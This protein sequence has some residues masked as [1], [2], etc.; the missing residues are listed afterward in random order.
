MSDPTIAVVTRP[1]V[2]Y[3]HIPHPHIQ[4]RRK[5]GPVL[6]KHVLSGLNGRIATRITAVVGTMGCA[7]LF[8]F[9]TLPALPAAIH[10]ST[11]SD[12]IPL[13]SWITQTFIQ[14]VLLPVIMVGQAIQSAAGDARS[15][16]IFNDSEAMLHE[17]VEIQKHMSSQDLLIAELHAMIMNKATEA[18]PEAS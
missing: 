18:S 1:R 7:Y 5:Q 13:I 12:P 17:M 15:L 2:P 6:T 16:Q 11:I 8:V 4:A 14:L 10:N 3:I 9:L